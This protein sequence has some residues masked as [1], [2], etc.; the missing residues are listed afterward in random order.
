M[1]KE[2]RKNPIP[3]PLWHAIAAELSYVP[4]TEKDFEFK[5]APPRNNVELSPDF[6]DGFEEMYEQMRAL[7]K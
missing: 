3:A 6:M 4:E 1:T 5:L 2:K 7:M